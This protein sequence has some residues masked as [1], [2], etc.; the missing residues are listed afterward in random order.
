M[1]TYA[2]INLLLLIIVLLVTFYF[3]YRFDRRVDKMYFNLLSFSARNKS[4]LSGLSKFES[5]SLSWLIGL[6]IYKYLIC[7]IRNINQSWF[8][9]QILIAIILFLAIEI[10]DGIILYRISHKNR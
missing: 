6:V 2:L 5:C 8:N 9:R 10:I 1:N 7:P 4:L 3:I